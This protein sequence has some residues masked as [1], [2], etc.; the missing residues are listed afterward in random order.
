MTENDAGNIYVVNNEGT[1]ASVGPCSN[2]HDE[3]DHANA[4]F[5]AAAPKLGSALAD[6][7]PIIREESHKHPAPEWDCLCR[8]I[9]EALAEAGY[10]I[11]Q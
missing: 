8:R 5:I 4:K 7:F 3:E 11:E 6:A 2:E 10:V 9:R 1:L